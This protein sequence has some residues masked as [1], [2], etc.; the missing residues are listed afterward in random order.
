MWVFPTKYA[1]H[2]LVCLF[3]VVKPHGTRGQH[4]AMT[5]SRQA[6]VRPYAD[7]YSEVGDDDGDDDTIVSHWSVD[8]RVKK[9]LYD[10]DEVRSLMAVRCLIYSVIL[11]FCKQIQN[12]LFFDVKTNVLTVLI[13]VTFFIY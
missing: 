8:E 2:N 10:D 1:Q 12:I 5:Y 13:G 7:P 11:V 6:R 4:A 9:L 3:S